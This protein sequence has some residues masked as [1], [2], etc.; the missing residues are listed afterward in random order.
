MPLQPHEYVVGDGGGEENGA[1]RRGHLRAERP[2]GEQVCNCL[3]SDLSDGV[4]EL[5]RRCA[6]Q[7]LRD[8]RFAGGREGGVGGR[9]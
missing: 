3:I 5:R 2:C 7:H 9:D 8:G 6:T 1:S 4:G